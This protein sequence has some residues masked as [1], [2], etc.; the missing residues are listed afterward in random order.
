MGDGNE[1]GSRNWVMGLWEGVLAGRILFP[2]FGV[3]TLPV[4]VN[5]G[6]SGHLE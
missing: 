2:F 6:G 4:G 3:F 5:V 1:F